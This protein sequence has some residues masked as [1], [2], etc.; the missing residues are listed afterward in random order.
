MKLLMNF[1]RLGEYVYQND[2]NVSMEPNLI[3]YN[4]NFRN[5]TEETFEL[6][7]SINSK[8][9]KVNVDLVTIIYNNEN[10]NVVYV[11]DF[12]YSV[13]YIEPMIPL[14]SFLNT[15]LHKC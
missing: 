11:P 14:T 10:L 6:I 4:T 7:K 8:R 15:F 12:E 1:L 5:K 3:I 2:T 13:L 9:L